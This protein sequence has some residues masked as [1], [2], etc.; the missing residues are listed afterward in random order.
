MKSGIVFEKSEPLF[1]KKSLI[2]PKFSSRN[3]NQYLLSVKIILINYKTDEFPK[4]YVKEFK[5]SSTAIE[6]A[7]LKTPETIKI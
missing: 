3:G 4:I 6:R 5:K 7:F 1:E 2:W